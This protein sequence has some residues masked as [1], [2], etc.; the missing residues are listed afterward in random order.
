MRGNFVMEINASEEGAVELSEKL[1][2][3][4]HPLAMTAFQKAT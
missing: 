2:I 1:L 4:D 3:E